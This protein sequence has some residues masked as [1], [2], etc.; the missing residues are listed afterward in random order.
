VKKVKS[1]RRQMTPEEAVERARRIVSGESSGMTKA[2]RIERSRHDVAF[3][4]A[5]YLRPYF[6]AEP[7]EFHKE[8]VEMMLAHDRG[9]AAAPRE[10]AKSTH[11]SFGFPIHQICHALVHFVVIFRES[12]TIA[13]QNVDDIRQ[14]L[15]ENEL[16][17]E[18]FGDLV[19]DRK[20]AGAEFVTSNK[21]KVLGRGRG[22]SARGLR[23]KQWRP[24]LV[25]LDDI[26][27]DELVESKERRDKLHRWIKRVVSNI[28]APNGKLFMIGTVLHHD[29]VL[30]RM[31][32]QTDVYFT[33]LWKAILDNGKPLWPARWP[34]ERLEAKKKEI[35]ARDFATEFMNDPANEEDQI[36]SPN[37]WKY[38]TDDD[39][40][41]EIDT[42]AA[43]DPAIGLKKKNDDT[44]ESIVG[45]RN[46][47]Y[48]VLRVTLKKLKVQQQ[49]QLVVSTCR[50][51]PR[52]R[53][54]AIETVAYQ[55]ALKQ[56]VEEASSKDNLQ[57][58]IV[59]PEDQS[60]DKL[61]RI[62]TLAPMAEQGRIY[63]PSAS[64]SYWTADVK[65]CIEQF[66]ALGCSANSHDDGPDVVERA[67]RLHRGKNSRKGTVSLL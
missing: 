24:D 67:I 9:V 36:F 5:Y 58:P 31:L 16:I 26:E 49:V 59:A 8:L 52:L 63:F 64:S 25:I 23:Y 42:C 20:W 44:A 54:Y 56:L 39:V 66:E 2:E 18:D 32:A 34:I 40:A 12:D 14:E 19:G 10:H 60:S 45:E 50:E 65:K 17:R 29:S 28:V 35:G 38:F 46:G 37:N 43:I 21:V 27:D 41:G 61:K 13:T 30:V 11:V 15:E 33:R 62:S 6:N 1:I 48:Y 22:S 55:A 51:F 7:A 57:L 53:K 4:F 3:F 47:N